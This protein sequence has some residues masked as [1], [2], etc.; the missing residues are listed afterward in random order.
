M[1]SNVKKRSG[2][3]SHIIF[4]VPTSQVCLHLHLPHK[5]IPCQKGTSPACKY[6]NVGQ[7]TLKGRYLHFQGSAQARLDEST[8]NSFSQNVM[9]LRASKED[10]CL[11][12][13][14]GTCI[15][16]SHPLKAVSKTDMGEIARC[17]YLSQDHVKILQW[18]FALLSIFKAL[19]INL[20]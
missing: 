6:K 1:P 10:C 12:R 16:H 15:Q 20:L 4:Q 17:T 9:R 5:K 19:K 11:D 18:T 13:R 2:D 8:V 7:C 14:I 3:R